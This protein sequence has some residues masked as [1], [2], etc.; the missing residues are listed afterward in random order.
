MSTKEPRLRRSLTWPQ[1]LAEGG[2][3]PLARGTSHTYPGLSVSQFGPSGPER[4]RSPRR[5]ASTRSARPTR[6][7]GRRCGA[8]S[9]APSAPAHVEELYTPCHLLNG[10]CIVTCES[11]SSRDSHVIETSH[12]EISPLRPPRPPSLSAHGLWAARMRTK[13]PR[14]Q[15]SVWSFRKSVNICRPCVAMQTCCSG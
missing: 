13:R 6:W 1:G 2:A 11:F 8:S 10:Y 3:V 9:I 15:V 14:G 4:S 5:N 7:G 12:I